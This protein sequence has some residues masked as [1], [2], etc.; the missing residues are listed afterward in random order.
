[1]LLNRVSSAFQGAGTASIARSFKIARSTVRS[2]INLFNSS[3][4][5]ET[6]ISNLSAD[7]VA[8]SLRPQKNILKNARHARLMD[9][10]FD[11]INAWKTR[12]QT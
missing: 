10:F 8:A 6:D 4:I 11:T 1:M 2:Y 7:I 9:L 5:V 3:D 12:I